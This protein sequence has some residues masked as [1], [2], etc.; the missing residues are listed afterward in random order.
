MN[1]IYIFLIFLIFYI[2]YGFINLKSGNFYNFYSIPVL[3]DGRIKPLGTLSDYEYKNILHTYDEKTIKSLAKIFFNPKVFLTEKKIYINDYNIKSN[4][5]LEDKKVFNALELL[6]SFRKNVELINLMLKAD[7]KSLNESQKKILNIYFD[8]LLSLDLSKCMDLISINNVIFDKSKGLIKNKYELILNI[9]EQNKFITRDNLEFKFL[10]TDEN[11]WTDLNGF[12][13]SK[14]FKENI[15]MSLLSEM[16]NFFLN[17]NM[18]MWDKKCEEFKNLNFSKISKLSVFFV[19]I[20]VIYN[21]LKFISTSCVLF[22]ICSLLILFLNKFSFLKKISKLFFL[23]GFLMLFFDIFFRIILTQKS[24]VTSLHESLIFVNFVFTLYFSIFL[25]KY[26]YSKHFL[27]SAITSFLLSLISIKLSEGHN[28]KSVVAV[29]N[30]NFW[31][32]IHVL[33]ISIGYGFCLI[34]GFLS[35]FYLYRSFKHPNIKNNL[36]AYIFYITLLALFFSFVG[37][38]LGG[39]WADQSWGRFWGWDPKENGALLIVLWLTLILHAKLSNLISE[40]LF[41]IGVILNLTIL[42]LAWF[43]VNL[44][45]IGLHSYGFIENIGTGLIIY[46]A[47][48]I[49]IIAGFFI[50]FKKKHY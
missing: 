46:I 5:G 33:T 36:Y 31:L 17:N 21:C 35:H 45:S 16:S 30:T 34:S 8:I 11:N 40:I 48:E 47:F 25:F 39:I 9:D 24:P 44:L 42:A 26:K 41:I 15:E 13:I 6:D 50:L 10:I 20:E 38:L 43:G 12:F 4:L 37:T 1:K 49:F 28:F 27:V 22:L 29:L 23:I 7:F 2:F 14:K 32:I 19:K 3:H 18:K